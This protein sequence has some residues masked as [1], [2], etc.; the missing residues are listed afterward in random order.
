MANFMKH[1]ILFATI[2]VILAIHL[3]DPS[4]D[5]EVCSEREMVQKRLV[6]SL[7]HTGELA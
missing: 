2:N 5:R 1:L 6:T 4:V 3:V 7:F